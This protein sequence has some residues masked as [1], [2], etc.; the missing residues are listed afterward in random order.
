[1]GVGKCPCDS[2][3]TNVVTCSCP[4]LA[5]EWVQ[6][7]LHSPGTWRWLHQPT[8]FGSK[9][10]GCT[11]R[12]VESNVGEMRQTGAGRDLL[13]PCTEDRQEKKGKKDSNPK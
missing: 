5:P 4:L 1:M 8:K 10:F 7:P 6:V 12:M 11:G 13:L 3:S 9:G 2:N